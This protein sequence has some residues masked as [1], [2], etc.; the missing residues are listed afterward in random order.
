MSFMVVWRDP[1]IRKQQGITVE[2]EHEAETLKRLLD[3]NGQNFAVAQHAIL[4]NE[5]QAILSN[6]TKMPTVAD[7]IQEHIDLLVRAWA[8]VAVFRRTVACYCLLFVRLHSD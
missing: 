7:V 4:E 6:K 5:K 1:K 2:S 8:A 3:A